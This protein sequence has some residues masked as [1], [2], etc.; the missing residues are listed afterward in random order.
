[1]HPNLMPRLGQSRAILLLSVCAFETC[2]RENFTCLL[3][4]GSSWT[5]PVVCMLRQPNLTLQCEAELTLRANIFWVRL[6]QVQV[7]CL[8]HHTTYVVHLFIYTNTNCNFKGRDRIQVTSGGNVWKAGILGG[9][10]GLVVCRQTV[11]EESVFIV[12]LTWQYIWVLIQIILTK[13]KN[14]PL[15]QF[16]VFF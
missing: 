1:M 16:S 9:G 7:C 6:V 11:G 13:Q 10:E 8:L 12:F 5:A 14:L 2:Y 4:V 3:V 15:E